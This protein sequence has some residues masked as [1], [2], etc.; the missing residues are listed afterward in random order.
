MSLPA[1]GRDRAAILEE[2]AARRDGDAD[3]EDARTWSLVYDPGE[4]T[5][6]VRDDAYLAFA[7]ENALNPL[8]FPSILGFETEVVDMVAS[9]AGADDA[10]GNVT[11]GGTESILC[12]VYAAR[13]RARAAHGIDDPEL[14]LPETAHPAWDKA[15]HYLGLEAIRTPAR[16]DWRADPAAMATAASDAT[17]L[18]VASAPSYPHGVVDPVPEVAAVAAEHDAWCHVDACI[19]GFVLPFLDD[20]GFDVPAWD[21]TVDGVTSISIDPHKYGYTA[22]GVSTVLYRG[23]DHRRHQYYAFDDWPGGIYA[24]PNVQGTR[25]AGP[26]AAAWAVMQY[27]GRDGYCDLVADAMAATDRIVEHVEA[28]D[29]LRVVGDPDLC[30]LG[31][32]SADPAV[33][34]WTVQRELADR[35]WELERQQRPESVHLSVMAGHRAVIDEFLGD[36][37]AAV[38]AART[39][40]DDEATAP[41][42]GLSGAFDAGDEPTETVRDLLN[43]VFQ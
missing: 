3:W 2:M 31:L 26:I 27:L 13:E 42:Y 37:D 11:S 8:A 5:R 41:L 15:A 29:A 33:H 4:A 34:A 35:G 28:H 32:A 30:L 23:A 36:L 40:T 16:E 20:L 19:G 38:E 43:A 6:E 25:P 22:K 24:S 7:S 39:E 9:L 14:L 18:V 10:V 1:T 17:A 21:F 12:A